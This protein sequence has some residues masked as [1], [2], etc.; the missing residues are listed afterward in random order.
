[1]LARPLVLAALLT[2]LFVAGTAVAAAD[3][4]NFETVP[5]RPLA[6][7]PDGS[8]LF[9]VNTPDARLEIFEVRST[10][11]VHRAS[12][13]V[14]LE[15]VAV[16]VRSDGEVWVVNHLSDSVSVVDVASDPPRVVRTLLVGDE[17]WDVVFA[18]DRETPAAP[19]PRAFVS[20]TRRGQN[21][22]ERPHDDYKVPGVGRADVWVF[23]ADAPG[24]ALGGTPEKIV[25]LFGD[26]PRSLAASPDGQSVF[27]TVFHSGN[28]T[29]AIN[30]AA[31]CDGGAD[32][33]KCAQSTSGVDDPPEVGEPGT[34]D[35]VI[36]PGGL[37]APNTDSDGVPQE[38]VGLIVKWNA[39]TAQWE[40]E[41]GRNW[42]GAVP[43]ELPDYD[44]FAIDA[45]AAEPEATHA[46]SGVGTINFQTVVHPDGRLYVAN[47]EARNEVR[48]EGSG[49]RGT[50]VRGHLHE[51]RVTVI[52]P[53]GVEPRHLNKHID[54]RVTPV[55]AGVKERTLAQPVALTLSYDGSQLFVAAFG[56]DAIGVFETAQLDADTFSPS[57]DARI[58]VS[59]G[60]PAGMALDA[61][62][63]RLFVY[64]RFDNGVAVLDLAEG[65]EVAK[66]LLHSPEPAVVTTGRRILYDADF[67]S[68]NGESSCGTCHVFGDKDDLAWDL[69]NPD[70]VVVENT[71]P[72]VLGKADEFNPLKGPMTT[73]T[74]RGMDN[75]G[76][77]HWRG[78]RSAALDPENGDFSDEVAAFEQF[79]GAFESLLGRDEGQI[80]A[81]D[82]SAFAE[83]ALT[84]FPPP[85]PIRPLDN[86]DTP[87]IARGRDTFMNFKVNIL[88][89]C[90]RC[91]T[92]AP[93]S[94]FF[95]TEGL[96]VFDPGDFK[97]PHLRNV[98]DKVG[99]FGFI[100]I[101]P[102]GNSG[103]ML[104]PQIRGT[105]LGNDGSVG[106]VK[107]FLL[108]AGF[109]FPRGD[110]GKDE[111]EN[112]V[113][114]F[115]SNLAPIVGQQVTRRAESSGDVE[116]RIALMMEQ[117]DTPWLVVGNPG[118]QSCDLIV[119][120]VLAGEERGWHFDPAAGAF[121]DD[122]GA[123]WLPESLAAVADEAGQELTYTCA[124]PGAAFRMGVDRD[125][126]GTRD[127]DERDAGTDPAAPGSVPGACSDEID[128][129]GD[130]AIDFPDDPDC[131]SV[132]ANSE[133]PPE[134]AP[135]VTIDVAPR[136]ARDL[137]VL[138]SRARVPVAV[139]G[140]E[141]VD[142]DRIDYA[143]LRFGPDGASPQPVPSQSLGREDVDGDG[144]ADLLAR[145]S[146]RES[147]LRP[148]DTEACLEGT[149]EGVPF[150][151]CDAVRVRK[152]AP[153]PWWVRWLPTW[154]G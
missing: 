145:F 152:P 12:V 103:T 82:M 128:N 134:L 122:R 109:K 39:A 6:L 144:H 69:G 135:E 119:K 49:E 129:D 118:T 68:S 133:L 90:E 32:R 154:A 26:K 149:L 48:F 138:R 46:Y 40:D 150:R 8:R 85:N 3:Y 80:S 93:L 64:T 5:V 153:R 36:L 115:P 60:G 116:D 83:F 97:I 71:N 100:G 59:G 137:L 17:P 1:M 62:G 10:R 132:E 47:T 63:E 4:T 112:F 114:Q 42:N 101:N 121:L 131:V 151:A 142:V 72:F 126:D 148:G 43:F 102:P 96:S 24:E 86:R 55:P 33:G 20:A 87:D 99:A 141:D 130:G 35:P 75:H 51:A 77:M 127:G 106:S 38:E 123:A 66:L 136:R 124:P 111:V 79:N 61:R 52:G 2:A 67:S 45:A 15:P 21:H 73:Q 78:D 95:G 56:S 11:L 25:Q 143:G 29:A 92:L 81:A 28:Q 139:F 98:Y 54:Y 58:P 41:L 31:V 19:F 125:G 65:R 105:G 104:G 44:V 120:G 18:G 108:F 14:G 140:S 16:N 50:T 53:G 74:L 13:P 37:P 107:S 117:A 34:G 88:G 70:G 91:H 113:L 7:S 22:P 76:P 110:E 23:D 146:L 89:T 27:A 57:A 30:G 84:I 147:G 94:G 9:A